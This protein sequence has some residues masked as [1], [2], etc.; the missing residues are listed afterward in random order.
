MQ[1]HTV[2]GHDPPRLAEDRQRSFA[3]LTEPR[4]HHSPPVVLRRTC[5][6]FRKQR[7]GGG[8]AGAGAQ[9]SLSC[10]L[11]TN[12]V[13]REGRRARVG[14]VAAS[15]EMGAVVEAWVMRRARV[16][17]RRARAGEEVA[18]H[19]PVIGRLAAV[20]G[21]HSCIRPRV[22]IAPRCA[23]L[24]GLRGRARMSSGVVGA[25]AS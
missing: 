12:G 7:R 13:A 22:C 4:W 8:L 6:L 23:S 3:S 15:A 10:G 9:L 11:V 24:L 5:T 16:G 14:R 21:P 20:R 2:A 18:P 25:L 1:R 17:F 19:T